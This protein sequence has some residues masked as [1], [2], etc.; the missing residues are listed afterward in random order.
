M[1]IKYRETKISIDGYELY[2]YHSAP[3]PIYPFWHKLITAF[4]IYEFTKNK[5]Y[6]TFKDCYLIVNN[7]HHKKTFKRK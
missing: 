7:G 1:L 5:F 3:S 6:I 4:A 2:T